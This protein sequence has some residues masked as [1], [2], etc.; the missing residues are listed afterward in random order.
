ME[1][2]SLSLSL[3]PGGITSDNSYNTMLVAAGNKNEVTKCAVERFLVCSADNETEIPGKFYLFRGSKYQMRRILSKFNCCIIYFYSLLGCHFV[4]WTFGVKTIPVK[5]FVPSG[6][7][8]S[9]TINETILSYVCKAEYDNQ[10][11]IGRYDPAKDICICMDL[12]NKLEREFKFGEFEI[13]DDPKTSLFWDTRVIGGTIPANVHKVENINGKSIILG[14]C[15]LYSEISKG[16][17]IIAGP[18]VIENLTSLVNS[19]NLMIMVS[20]ED[21]TFDCEPDQFL[22]CNE[23]GKLLKYLI[24]ILYACLTKVFK[25]LPIEIVC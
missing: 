18:I 5:Q 17:Y 14:R 10:E 3:I 6:Q 2:P 1:Q 9:D 20:F 22:V 23:T 19:D 15:I 24:R 12:N 8:S 7:I 16:F 11:L 13:L 25:K 21:N 4:R